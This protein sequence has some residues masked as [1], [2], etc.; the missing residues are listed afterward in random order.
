MQEYLQ[1]LKDVWATLE[2]LGWQPMPIVGA[3]IAMLAARSYFEPD[4]LQV[5]TP[6]AVKNMGRIKLMIFTSVLFTSF[7]LQI[8]LAKPHFGFDWCLSFGFSIIDTM[9]GYVFSSSSIVRN[10]LKNGLFKGGSNATPSAQ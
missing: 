7:L 1:P 6:E 8:G 4:I 2:N 5:N 10:F 9:A 3:I